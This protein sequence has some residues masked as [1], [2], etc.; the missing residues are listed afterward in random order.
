MKI[1]QEGPLPDEPQRVT[2]SSTVSA[3]VEVDD[4]L[5][6]HRENRRGDYA[7]ITLSS[8]VERKLLTLLQERANRK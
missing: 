6:L 4:F 7:R 2:L 1:E 8:E 5:V 3:T